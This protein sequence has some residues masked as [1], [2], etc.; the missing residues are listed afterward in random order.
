MNS[1]TSVLVIYGFAALINGLGYGPFYS[2]GLSFVDTNAEGEHG[3]SKYI[4]TPEISP[5]SCPSSS[6]F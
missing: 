5:A 3:A 1:Y 2:L 6:L 4:G